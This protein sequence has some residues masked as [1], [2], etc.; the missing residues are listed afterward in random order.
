M[1]VLLF[2][3]WILLIVTAIVATVCLLGFLLLW[4]FCSAIICLQSGI[5]F[6]PLWVLCA[7]AELPATY[8]QLT[9]FGV[10]SIGG[11]FM[12][13]FDDGFLLANNTVYIMNK[14]L[15]PIRDD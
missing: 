8:V 13:I 12:V 14:K 3:F 1:D 10:S 11:F 6:V 4:A 2:F 15:P 5:I 7:A 9:W